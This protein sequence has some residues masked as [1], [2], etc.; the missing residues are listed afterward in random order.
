MGTPW[1]ARTYDHTSEPQQAWA[2][3]VLARLEGV[4][5]DATVR[6]NASAVRGHEAG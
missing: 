4:A 1:D 5:P 2:S 3:E 6:L